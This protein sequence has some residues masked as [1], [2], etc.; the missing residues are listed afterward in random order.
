MWLTVSLRGA[1]VC[2]GREPGRIDRSRTGGGAGV[3]SSIAMVVLSFRVAVVRRPAVLSSRLDNTG[4]LELSNIRP[5]EL[6][7][8]ETPSTN[9]S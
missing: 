1:K 4:Y 6:I 5:S 3:E 2:G 7:A 8:V 9:A